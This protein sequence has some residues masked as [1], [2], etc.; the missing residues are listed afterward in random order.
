M[1]NTTK[2]PKIIIIPYGLLTKPHTSIGFRFC[3]TQPQQQRRVT[4]MV[5]FFLSEGLSS[6]T[7][8]GITL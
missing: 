1:T 6:Y 4:D 7:R 3:A 5:T 2:S 8:L